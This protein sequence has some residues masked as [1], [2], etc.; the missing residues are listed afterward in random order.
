MWMIVAALIV[1]ASRNWYVAL[2]GLIVLTGVLEHPDM[3]RSL[4]GL[5]GLNPWNLLLGVIVLAW[6]R[7]RWQRRL[8]S[9]LPPAAAVLLWLGVAVVTCAFLRLLPDTDSLLV[10]PGLGGVVSDY[11]VNP[12]KFAVVGLLLFQGCR[13]RTHLVLAIA[14]LLA[15]Y[16]VISLQVL[17]WVLPSGA[18]SGGDLSAYTIR[19]LDK[20]VGLH[21]NDLSVMLAGAFWAFL[22]V[23]ALPTALATRLGVLAA[24]LPVLFAQVLTGGR[25]GYLAWAVAGLA[26][27]LVRWRRYL[28]L[29]PFVVL[30]VAWLVPGVADRALH[31]LEGR[32]GL[33]ET[34]ADLD[35][36]SA[37]RTQMWP[38][39]IVKI[40]EAPFVGYGRA[41]TQR[42][43]L[44]A[45]FGDLLGAG[46]ILHPHNAYLEMLLDSGIVGLAITLAIYMAILAL[47][48]ALLRD[49]RRPEFLAVGGMAVALVLTQLV[50]A[51]TGQSFWPREATLGMW[52]A[53]GLLLRVWIQ[54]ARWSAGTRAAGPLAGPGGRGLRPRDGIVSTESLWPTAATP[55][56]TPAPAWWM[57][58]QGVR[59]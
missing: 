31:G 56:L 23:R 34:E 52:C 24:S 8:P 20:E 5:P 51:F 14:A 1:H 44:S 10:H 35:T 21:R 33:I 50:G 45:A 15:L 7:D 55:A 18:L 26:L 38:L 2:C 37:G 42:T 43:G 25:G 41:A 32:Q 49:R 13:N 48:L 17:R 27:G 9:D 30:L 54:R 11:L 29:A 19:K 36:L 59:R 39:V 46:L 57:R 4:L 12:L 16:L 40:L 22:A 53:A 3:P 47:G 6:I 28:L 58:G